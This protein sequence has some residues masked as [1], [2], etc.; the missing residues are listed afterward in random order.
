MGG[1]W[2]VRRGE[3][4]EGRRGVTSRIFSS[5]IQATGFH[6]YPF[7]YSALFFPEA[8]MQQA[9]TQQADM[10]QADTVQEGWKRSL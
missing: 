4:D 3:G 1:G 6:S 2:G 7:L 9:D 10:Q 8:D 5:Y